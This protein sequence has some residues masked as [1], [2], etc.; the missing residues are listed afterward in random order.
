MTCCTSL[1]KWMD[2]VLL[3]ASHYHNILPH[4]YLKI[5]RDS[6]GHIE[7]KYGGASC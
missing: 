6:W 1:E 3:L 5:I 4:N 7:Q 2:I